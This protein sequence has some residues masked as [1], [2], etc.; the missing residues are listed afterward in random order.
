MASYVDVKQFFARVF[1]RIV[2]RKRFQWFLTGFFGRLLWPPAATAVIA[3]DQ[4]SRICALD[5]NGVFRFPG[6][7]VELGEDPVESAAR[8]FKE[9]TGLEVKILELK[10][11]ITTP[12]IGAVLLVYSGRIIGGTKQG[13]W[14][15]EP[16]MLEKQEVE[17]KEW[18]KDMVPVLDYI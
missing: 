11:A 1:S 2:G 12:D 18:D 6:G 14:E 13:S 8:E 15:G 7:I 5:Y 17:N 16:V 4:E 10:D 9:E 3:K